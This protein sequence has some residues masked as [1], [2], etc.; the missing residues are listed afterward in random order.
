MSM[1]I[2]RS[3]IARKAAITRALNKVGI[4]ITEIA[5][6]H[7]RLAYQDDRGERVEIDYSSGDNGGYVRYGST[8]YWDEQGSQ[9]F[10][11]L[12]SRWGATLFWDAG[13]RYPRLADLIRSR[14]ARCARKG[15]MPLSQP[16][17]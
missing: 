14:A 8:G 16:G 3:E 17:A 13:Y 2:D 4:T 1:D 5:R 6:N 11:D 12:C 10:D 7:V 15:Y 9:V